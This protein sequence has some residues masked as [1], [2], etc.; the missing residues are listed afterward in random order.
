MSIIQL[1]QG[2]S[3]WSP[4]VG[5][6]RVSEVMTC[7]RGTPGHAKLFKIRLLLD[8]LQEKLNEIPVEEHVA[9]D[10]QFIPTKARPTIQ[11]YM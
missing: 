8:R 4:H 11:Q 6:P 5:H 3:Y 10:E 1:P 2:R 9:R 7:N